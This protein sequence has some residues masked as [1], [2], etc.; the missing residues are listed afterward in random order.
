LGPAP[1]APQGR[2]A[3]DDRLIFAPIGIA[4]LSVYASTHVPQAGWAH[5]FGL[6][7][8]FGDTV[9]GAVLGMLPMS[10]ALGLRIA[11]LATAVG[12]VWIMAFVLGFTRS[13]LA[14]AGR[15]GVRSL[16]FG[17]AGLL[18]LAGRGAAGLVRGIAAGG[19]AVAERRATRSERR[20]ESPEQ[21]LFQR[22]RSLTRREATPDLMTFDDAAQDPDDRLR[23]RISNAI[24]AKVGD[25]PAAPLARP[26]PPVI[27]QADASG[28]TP[29]DLYDEDDLD[30]D[31]YVM[32]EPELVEGRAA[33]AAT[34]VYASVRSAEPRRGASCSTP[35]A[36]PRSPRRRRDL[37]HEALEENARMLETVLD[38]YGVKGEIVAVRPGPVVTM[39]ELEPAPG[40]KAS[41]VIGLAD[42][43]ARSDV[44]A[45]GPRLHRAGPLGHRDRTAE[46]LAREGRPA[47]DPVG[48]RLR[49]QPDAAAAGARARTSAASRSSRTSPRC[50]TC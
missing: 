39:Y 11:A 1:S 31:D 40:L 30:F 49:R 33:L 21:G 32:P 38:D 25:R 24:R 34:A 6:G 22:L 37:S 17:Y 4:L 50:P 13:E 10:A 46:R 5:S 12:A 43:I 15:F 23:A 18:R 8:L 29:V 9:L 19:A 47:R 35:R 27:R 2:R 36:S 7:G 20:E 44:G 41:R 28:A 3:R 26:E 42:D 14:A 45:V 48:A 16:V